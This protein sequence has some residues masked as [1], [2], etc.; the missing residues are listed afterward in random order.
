MIERSINELDFNILRRRRFTPSPAAWEDEV[1][2]FM[3]LDRFS[4]G[5]ETGYQDNQGRPVTN[6]ITPPFQ[7]Q[8]TGNAVRTEA[9]ARRWQDAGARWNGGTLKGLASK[10]GYLQRL[11]VT[12]VWVSPIFKQISFQDTY[13]GY[14]IQNFLDVDPHFGNRN[15]LRAMVR[16]AHRYGIH[17]IL[18]IILNHVGNVFSYVPDR[19]LERDPFSGREYMD[20][21]WDGRPYR[22]QGFND[23]TGQP[24]LPFGIVNLTE[25]PAAWPNDAIWP[26]EFQSPEIYSARGHITNWDHDPE[27]FE[28]DFYDLKDVRLGSGSLDDYS[29]SPTLLALCQVYKFWIA[30]ADVDGFRIDTVKHMDPGAVRYFASVIHEFAQSIGKENFYLIGEITGGRQRAFTSLEQ[31]GLNAALG[32]DDIP[33]KLEYMVKG[34][35]NPEEYFNLFRNSILVQKESHI[36]FRNK[37]VTLFD[38][39]DQVRKGG[40]KARFAAGDPHWQQLL[41]NVLAVNATTMGIPC[42]YYGS[43]QGFDGEGDSDRYLRESMFGG[44]FGAFRSRG[45]HFFNEEHPVYQE[46]SRLL[47]LRRDKI[48]LRRGRQ[49]LREISG[50]G[51]H[52]GLPR[53][54]GGQIR[55]IIP[56]SRLF[57]DQE[58]LLATNTDPDNPRLAWIRLQDNLHQP[59]DHLRCLYSKNQQAVAQEVEIVQLGDRLAVQLEIPPAGFVI[60]Q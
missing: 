44:E 48:A 7:V 1:L 9:D 39:H 36:W 2:Y 57:D 43:E 15:D 54:I 53:M 16:T 22:V 4:N 31:T 30:Y 17:V 27:F 8:E 23:R 21:R 33:D 13:H 28:G 3:M 59:G 29:P 45:R 46:L 32:I 19:Y 58:I 60:Y 49:Y 41:V 50:D 25:H 47:K 37:I 40:Y 38:D 10:M 51:V 52:F 26:V 55:S 5:R 42:I 20:P 24:N 34:Y 12:A 18:D 35:R 56:W 11:G 6:G 14:G